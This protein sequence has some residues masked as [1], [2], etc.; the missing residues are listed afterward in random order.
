MAELQS[1]TPPTQETRDRFINFVTYC[2]DQ[3]QK[4]IHKGVY[5][6]ADE[7]VKMTFGV[8][9]TTMGRRSPILSF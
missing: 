3:A 5:K 7:F 8:L 6:I 9:N 1:F 4:Q 2:L